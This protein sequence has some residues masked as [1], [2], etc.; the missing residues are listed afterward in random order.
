VKTDHM[1]YLYLR[2]LSD[3]SRVRR[4]HSLAVPLV[5]IAGMLTV[6]S[7]CSLLGFN[8]RSPNEIKADIEKE[9]AQLVCCRIQLSQLEDGVAKL[10]GR[11]E[12]PEQ[13]LTIV[14]TVKN[15][16]GITDVTA[17]FTVVPKSFVEV[18]NL[19][20]DFQSKNP[21]SSITIQPSKGCDE[22]YYRKEPIL[23]NIKATAP[24]RYVYVDYYTA[25]QN[26]VSHIV[27]GPRYPNNLINL[28]T[29]LQ[30]DGGSFNEPFGMELFTV[31]SS[32]MQ[33]IYPNRL[34][35]EE[36]S[37]YLPE[38]RKALF[39]RDAKV[40]VVAHTCLITTQ[41]APAAAVKSEKK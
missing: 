37:R 9:I 33:L 14:Q 16:K 39:S 11:V 17:D 40:N 3:F 34:K 30:P 12:S 8:K 1:N 41:A 24:L 28:A 31:I 2:L 26:K 36:T 38:L 10:T 13:K 4:W 19:L 20:R 35:P 6:N 25:D 23:L 7:G 15:I 27:P 22:T 18:I 5:V 29:S 21:E 32:S